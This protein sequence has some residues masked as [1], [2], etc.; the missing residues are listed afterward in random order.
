[1]K[2]KL[3]EDNNEINDFD[4]ELDALRGRE[5][6]ENVPALIKERENELIAL[7]KRIVEVKAS[8]TALDNKLKHQDEHCDLPG[9]LDDMIRDQ[10][11]EDLKKCEIIIT[12]AEKSRVIAESDLEKIRAYVKGKELKAISADHLAVSVE[13]LFKLRHDIE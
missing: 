11:R 6:D 9:E 1:M 13:L 3:D 8:Y 12:N 10:V 5:G 2:E 4:E 7:N